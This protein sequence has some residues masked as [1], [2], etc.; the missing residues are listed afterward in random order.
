MKVA[1]K[2]VRFLLPLALSASA[3]AGNDVLM[4]KVRF[5]DAEMA[6]ARFTEK[7]IKLSSSVLDVHIHK[8]CDFSFSINPFHDLDPRQFMSSVEVHR[9]D[10]RDKSSAH[11]STRYFREQFWIDQIENYKSKEMSFWPFGDGNKKIF[12]RVCSKGY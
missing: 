6:C 12:D 8:S 5:F 7:P 10:C 1:R 11:V 9:V 2:I 4:G 3:A